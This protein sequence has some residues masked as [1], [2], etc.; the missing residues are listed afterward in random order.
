MKTA[1]L[2]M[3]DEGRLKNGMVLLRRIKPRIEKIEGAFATEVVFEEHSSGLALS[4]PEREITR[5]VVVRAAKDTRLREG[6]TVVVRDAAKLAGWHWDE[7]GEEYI[8]T[9]AERDLSPDILF[10]YQVVAAAI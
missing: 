5:C 1:E 3:K 10:R 7:E 2:I 6:H 8:L 4:D 9:K